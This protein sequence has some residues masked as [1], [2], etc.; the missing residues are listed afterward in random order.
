MLRMSNKRNRLRN[1]HNRLQKPYVAHIIFSI[2]EQMIICVIQ[3]LKKHILQDMFFK[4]LTVIFQDN[5]IRY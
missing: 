3:I 2:E 4:Y 5:S 1:Q